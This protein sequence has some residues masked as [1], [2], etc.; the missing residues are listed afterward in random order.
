MPSTSAHRR[1]SKG[2]SEEPEE[3]P[4]RSNGYGIAN[5]SAET[6]ANQGSRL[7]PQEQPDGLEE[8]GLAVSLEAL[9]TVREQRPP[10]ET[11]VT[12][13]VGSMAPAFVRALVHLY[14]TMIMLAGAGEVA[15]AR[16]VHEMIGRL[17]TTPDESASTE[18]AFQAGIR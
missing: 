14:E 10:L 12:D 2:V 11:S 3:A 15:H 7:T 9:E 13:S 16:A 5:Q 18:F 8:S 1:E 17:L 4:T 6:L